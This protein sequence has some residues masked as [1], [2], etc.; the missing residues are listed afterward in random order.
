MKKRILIVALAICLCAIIAGSTIAYFSDTDSKT[1]SFAVGNADIE[2]KED[3]WPENDPTDPSKP[4]CPDVNPGV[5]YDKAPYVV[6]KGTEEVFARIKVEGL[7]C[8]K[9]L[10][11][12]GALIGLKFEG[13]DGFNSDDWTYYDGYYYYDGPLAAGTSTSYL[14]DQISIPETLG[15]NDS[16]A[17]FAVIVTGEAVQ[18]AGYTGT[19]AADLAAW[20]TTCIG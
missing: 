18:T 9:A 13:S 17:N 12:D 3:N 20:F 14:F 15:N 11:S 10:C 1:N 5:D 6:N 7:D 8:L 19:T 16:G 4:Y 2:L